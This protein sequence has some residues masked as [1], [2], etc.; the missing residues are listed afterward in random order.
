MENQPSIQFKK[1]RELG[2]IITDTF[3][4][5][6]ENYKVLF[7]VILKNVAIP[8]IIM[9][10]ALTYYLY[11]GADLFA[12]TSVPDGYS[13]SFFVDYFLSIFI[14]IIGVFIFQ[15]FMYASVLYSIKSY[16]NN[17]GII[18]PS[19]VNQEVS[20]NWLNF[21]GMQFLIGIVIFFGMMLCVLPGIYLLVPLSLIYSI[22]VFDKLGVSASF[23]YTFQ[24][25]KDNWWI[26]FATILVMAILVY[27]IA[28]IFQIPALIY[29][30]VKGVTIAQEG[31]M[32]DPTFLFDWVYI[33]LNVLSTLIQYI[34]MGLS[35]ISTVFIYFNLNEKKHQTGALEEIENLGSH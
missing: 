24:L 31:T 14:L 11:N 4:F 30:I 13:N 18:N 3:K 16:I 23:S 33:V 20:K 5:V 17:N 32:S 21:C 9:L 6:R 19:E 35:I 22:Y 1:E 10:A 12:F 26:S 8:G 15:A 7:Q 29:M 34:L 25:I 27:I 28:F 2:E